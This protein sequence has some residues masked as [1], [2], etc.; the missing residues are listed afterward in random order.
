MNPTP[1]TLAAIAC[2]TPQVFAGPLI[3]IS[4]NAVAA[5][6][7]TI[8]HALSLSAGNST[9]TLINWNSNACRED[10]GG[11]VYSNPLGICYGLAV[12]AGSGLNASVS[13]G[14]AN[15]NGIVEKAA[16]TVV[17]QA[18]Q[19]NWIWLKQDGTFVVET[20]TATPSV[21]SGT[22]AVLLGAAVTSGSAVTAVEFSGVVYV[23]N[24]F[25]ERFTADS[26]IP[27]D[28]PNANWR[29]FTTSVSTHVSYWWNGNHYGMGVSRTDLIA[30]PDYVYRGAGSPQ[31]TVTASLGSI[32]LD[33]T[34]GDLWM[35][36]QTTS[37]NNTSWVTISPLLGNGYLSKAITDAN[38]TLTFAEY[39]NSIIEVTGTLTADR[40][41]VLPLVAGGELTVGNLTT[42]G[43]N[44]VF[45]ATSGSTVT[46]ANGKRARIYSDGTNWIRA[47]ADV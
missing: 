17:L 28:S 15:I 22:N 12:S 2:P 20:S 27:A 26:A 14:H 5:N 39:S 34:N 8:P 3:K 7:P 18:S 23:N 1:V 41:I 36:E 35:K 42:G 10:L 11:S 4:D 40:N 45:K 31:G 24:G 13:A 46:V 44:L 43:F 19:T 33:V 9:D 47:T 6:P 29:G 25:L 16:S 38:T 30:G 37:P 21:P 32:Y